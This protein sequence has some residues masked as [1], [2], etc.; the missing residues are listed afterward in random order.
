MYMQVFFVIEISRNNR[1]GAVGM[2]NG[3]VAIF[4]MEVDKM[5]NWKQ[6]SEEEG[7]VTSENSRNIEQCLC[8]FPFIRIE[9]LLLL[10]GLLESSCHKFFISGGS[11]QNIFLFD[12]QTGA[13]V[14]AIEAPKSI[15]CMAEAS[16]LLVC[17]QSGM[18]CYGH[19]FNINTGEKVSK[20]QGLYGF[21][22]VIITADGK[23]VN[24]VHI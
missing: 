4:D 9:F 23:K 2:S 24:V 12:T 16:G 11:K 5:L 13:V 14:R 1:V 22:N 7:A 20:L 6:C 17:G 3:W 8:N 15:D 21:S 19:V 18:E 10:S